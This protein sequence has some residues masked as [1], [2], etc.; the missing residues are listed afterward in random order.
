MK[1]LYVTDLDGTLLK[2]DQTVSEY[3]KR[4]IND[5]IS[6]GELITYATARSGETA[7]IVTAGLNI[8]APSILYNGAFICDASGK[9]ILSHTFT[10]RDKE[11]ISELIAAGIYSIVYAIRNGQEKFSFIPDKISRAGLEF[12]NTR[13]TCTRYNPVKTIRELYD[14][15]TFY[16]TIIDDCD[17]LK[18]FYEKYKKNYNCVFSKDIYSGEYW[19]EIMHRHA[20]KADAVFELKQMLGCRLVV[21]GDEKND[22]D[23][24]RIADECYAVEN[25]VDELKAI[26]TAVIPDN[27]SDGVAKQLIKLIGN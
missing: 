6:R 13:K 5:L 17:K 27:E 2:K 18:P 15:E 8:K 24:F 7:G 25:A 14:G 12:N 3:S 19:L 21:F 23:M 20:N 22:I 11:M 16:I 4:I 1:T 10:E 9:I 26:A